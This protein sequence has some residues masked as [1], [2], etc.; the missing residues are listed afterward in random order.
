[1]QIKVTHTRFK[2]LYFQYAHPQSGW[3]EEYWNQFFETK[4]GDV[5]YFEAPESPLA[6]RMM[7]STGQNMHNM[8]FLTEDAEESFFQFPI[9]DDR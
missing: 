9:H 7:I 1:M 6:N 4:K 5:Y 2:E 3:T 8:F